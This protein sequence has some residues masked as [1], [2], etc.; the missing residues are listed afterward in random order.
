MLNYLLDVFMLP[1]DGGK[2]DLKSYFTKDKLQKRLTK[3]KEQKQIEHVS[4]KKIRVSKDML[5][6]DFMIYW[7]KATKNSYEQNTYGSYLMQVN[8]RI[9]PYFAET[10]IT[11]EELTSFDIQNYYT[12]C[13][14]EKK[15][16]Q[17]RFSNNMQI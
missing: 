7:I 9:T 15:L 3:K 6:S 1:K 8:K 5:F 12:Y 14:E 13:A 10:G 17:I 4:N 11:L 16:N 2:A